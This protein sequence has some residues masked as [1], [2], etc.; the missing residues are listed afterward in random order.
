MHI[1]LETPQCIA[2]KMLA[3]DVT[4][5]FAQ[6]FNDPQVLQRLKLPGPH[7]SLKSLHAWIAGV[8]TTK[9]VLMGVTSKDNDKV[10][11]I[12]HLHLFSQHRT[13]ILAFGTDI[14]HWTEQDLLKDS[15]RLLCN[16]FF[17]H[18]LVDKISV[19]ILSGDRVLVHTLMDS[20]GFSCEATLKQ[21][22][23][24]QGGNR[25]DITVLSCFKNPIL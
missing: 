5:E 1:H 6:W 24:T 8:D 9:H 22:V 23:L 13:A 16:C 10:L 11:G 21:E 17:Q 25:L 2:R 14:R 7:F 3:S 20:C 15:C 19:H 4:L 12:Y 18:G